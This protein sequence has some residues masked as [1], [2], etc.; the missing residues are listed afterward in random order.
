[1]LSYR[2]AEDEQKR[3][4]LIRILYSNHGCLTNNFVQRL[5]EYRLLKQQE[6]VCTILRQNLAAAPNSVQPRHPSQGIN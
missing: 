4:Y 6:K 5:K 3:T 1:M 2:Y